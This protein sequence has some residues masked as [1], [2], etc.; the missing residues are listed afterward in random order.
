MCVGKVIGTLPSK[1]ANYLL[2]RKRKELSEIE[3]R[4]EISIEIQGDPELP[5]WGG[6]LDFINKKIAEDI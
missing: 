2:N 6:D 4:Y 5:I 1:V 3:K